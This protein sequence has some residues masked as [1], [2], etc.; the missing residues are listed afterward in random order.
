MNTDEL[1]KLLENRQNLTTEPE[2]YRTNLRRTLLKDYQP[3]TTERARFLW[4]LSPGTRMIAVASVGVILV[5]STLLF[6]LQSPVSNPGFDTDAVFAAV[7]ANPEIQA[8]TKNDATT[9]I[10]VSGL[11]INNTDVTFQIRQAG[12]ITVTVG[13]KTTT[14]RY[15]VFIP[16]EPEAESFLS[17]DEKNLAMDVV[18]SS[19]EAKALLDAGANISRVF[20]VYV[21]SVAE[22]SNSYTVIKEQKLGEVWI[23]VKGEGAQMFDVDLERGTQWN[24]TGATI[25][26]ISPPATTP[27]HITLVPR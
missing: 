8:F 14:T 26:L 1:V 22:D 24:P 20:A 2:Y 13:G 5:A 25:G 18:K 6:N 16:R 11:W 17:P 4:W 9:D 15:L 19:P 3:L 21:L 27:I 7:L 23:E 10:L 12:T